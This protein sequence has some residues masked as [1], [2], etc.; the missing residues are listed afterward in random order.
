MRPANVGLND[1]A[2][3]LDLW[4]WFARFFKSRTLATRF[5]QSG[6]IRVNNDVIKKAHHNLRVGDVLTFPK[7]DQV[8]VVKLLDLGLRRGPAPEA[9]ALYEDLSPPA[10]KREG[11]KGGANTVAGVREPGSGRPTKQQRRALDRLRPH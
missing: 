9:Q 10:P 7:A 8:R 11:R 2:R 5:V 6:R 1:N 4:L 3:R